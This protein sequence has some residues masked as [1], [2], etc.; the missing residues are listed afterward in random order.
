M[1][2]SWWL[3][4]SRGRGVLFRGCSGCG[5]VVVANFPVVV[6]VRESGHPSVN[7]PP[8]M[9]AV[10]VANFPVANCYRVAENCGRVGG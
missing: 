7:T 2:F 9:V 6:L 8:R 3:I 5:V 10:L 1:Y 4:S